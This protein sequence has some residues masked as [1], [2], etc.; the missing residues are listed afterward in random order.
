MTTP[1][2]QAVEAAVQRIMD[3][4]AMHGTFR[5]E[6]GWNEAINKSGERPDKSATN[7]REKIEAALRAEL[8][9]EVATPVTDE[10]IEKFSHD[11]SSFKGAEPEATK[12]ALEQFAASRPPAQG[13]AGG[14]GAVDFLK[15]FTQLASEQGDH[16][17]QSFSK[18]IVKLANEAHKIIAATQA[19]PPAVG[20]SG[21]EKPVAWMKVTSFPGDD[22]DAYDFSANQHG[23][24]QTPLYRHP[25]PDGRADVGEGE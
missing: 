11:V 20:G 12:F 24:F 5:W 25:T 13:V 8:P 23:E 7:W 16:T 17:P 14:V 10:E 1:H 15:R 4:V 3:L 6:T 9:K 18:G 21:G 2:T 19:Q 22:W